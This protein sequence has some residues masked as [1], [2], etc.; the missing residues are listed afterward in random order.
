MGVALQG[1]YHPITLENASA[2]ILQY[3]IDDKK[4]TSMALD[5]LITLHYWYRQKFH[6][7]K[8]KP[9]DNNNAES[10]LDMYIKAYSKSV[11][12]YDIISSQNMKGY[13]CNADIRINSIYMLL[14]IAKSWCLNDKSFQG[15]LSVSYCL[16]KHIERYHSFSFEKMISSDRN[17][18]DE[19]FLWASERGA[20]SSAYCRAISAY[21]EQMQLQTNGSVTL[22]QFVIKNKVLERVNKGWNFIQKELTHLYQQKKAAIKYQ[23]DNKNFGSCFIKGYLAGLISMTI[24]S[25]CRVYCILYS[26]GINRFLKDMTEK[27]KCIPNPQGELFEGFKYLH[28]KMEEQIQSIHNNGWMLQHVSFYDD[29]RYRESVEYGKCSKYII[30][31][32]KSRK[33]VRFLKNHLRGMKCGH[34]LVND[35]LLKICGRCKKEQ[36][37]SRKCQKRHWIQHKTSC[38]VNKSIQM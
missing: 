10:K 23:P 38:F 14:D 1:G 25:L 3:Y 11:S 7:H 9:K 26:D 35:M 12:V 33:R 27:I 21:I 24:G 37:C 5:M 18:D 30:R 19:P 6:F 28:E 17:I 2:I 4:V 31:A 8:E 32:F 29:K 16:S 34:C 13:V 15:I 20:F 22:K 36:Y